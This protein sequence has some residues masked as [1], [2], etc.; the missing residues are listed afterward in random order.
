M[1]GAASSDAAVVPEP[2]C[3]VV[4]SLLGSLAIGLGWLSWAK[5]P[6]LLAIISLN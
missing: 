5:I 1:T 2:V 6:D 4:W 3:L